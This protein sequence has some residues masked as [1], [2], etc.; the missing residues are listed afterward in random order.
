MISHN[1]SSWCAGAMARACRMLMTAF[2]VL[3][4]S[5]EQDATRTENNERED[6]SVPHETS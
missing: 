5:D 4:E 3:R 6:R 2:L 1:L